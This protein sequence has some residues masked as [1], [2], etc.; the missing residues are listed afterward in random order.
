MRYR[1]IISTYM[2]TSLLH[3]EGVKPGHFL[4]MFLD[5]AGQASEPEIMVP[6]SNLCTS[7]TVVVLAGG[8]KQLGPVVYS[9]DAADFGLGK[10]YLERLFDCEHYRNKDE[11][12]VIKLVRN[13]RCHPAI[14]DLPSKLFYNGELLACKEDNSSSKYSRLISFLTRTFLY[15]SLEFRAVMRGKATTRRGLTESRQAKLLR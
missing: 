8:P 3:M 1:I 10:S 6:M 13:Y 9:R 14:L 12:F 7:E 4:H 11:S 2:S 15:Y 5:E